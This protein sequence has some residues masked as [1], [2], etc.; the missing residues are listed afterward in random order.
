MVTLLLSLDSRGALEGTQT[1]RDIPSLTGPASLAVQDWTFTPATLDGMPVPSACSVNVVF[2]PYNP[3]GAV[4]APLRLPPP[5]PAALPAGTEFVPP[6]ITAARFARYPTNSVS[7]G[8]VVL[9]LTIDKSGALIKTRVVRDVPSLTAP[10]V[11]AVKSWSFNPGTFR[12]EPISS[13]MIVAV[14]FRPPML[15]RP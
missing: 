6:Q 4:F 11:T 1:L 2:N 15:G 3:A 5:Q 12:G 7:S 8:A 13:K 10:V 14:V 9:S